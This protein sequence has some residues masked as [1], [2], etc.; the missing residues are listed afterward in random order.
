MFTASMLWSVAVV[1]LAKQLLELCLLGIRKNA[2]TY[3]GLQT[4]YVLM[5]MLLLHLSLLSVGEVSSLYVNTK[6]G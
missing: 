3:A 2:V 4:I 6:G 5:M 1:G